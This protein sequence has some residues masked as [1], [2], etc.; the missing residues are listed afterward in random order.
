[1]LIRSFDCQGGAARSLSA[2]LEGKLRN[3]WNIMMI[4]IS[5][6][7][8]HYD[9]SEYVHELTSANLLIRQENIEVGLQALPACSALSKNLVTKRKFVNKEKQ[10]P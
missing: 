3:K 4:L 6:Q 10:W 2:K 7:L 8:E 9:E 1:M 5:V